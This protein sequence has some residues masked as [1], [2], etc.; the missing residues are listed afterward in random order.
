[1]MNKVFKGKIGK[2]IEVYV[3]DMIVKSLEVRNHLDD[4]ERCFFDDLKA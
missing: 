2:T 4:L 3:D 1:M